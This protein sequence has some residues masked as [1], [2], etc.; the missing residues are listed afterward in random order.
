VISPTDPRWEPD[1]SGQRLAMIRASRRGALFSA[2]ILGPVVWIAVALTPPEGFGAPAGAGIWTLVMSVPGLALLGAGLTPAARGSRGSAASAGLAMGVGVPVAAVASA[3]IA[4]YLLAAFAK[5]LAV[6]G[7]AA[8]LVLRDGVT[9][10]VAIAPL[11]A[12]ASVLWVVAVRRYP[13]QISRRGP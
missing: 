8:G 11:I 10:A 12:I 2:L 1:P 5:D 7:Q 4:I 13:R 3:M 6:A 9:A